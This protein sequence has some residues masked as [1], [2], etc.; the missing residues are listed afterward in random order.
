MMEN[1]LEI[2]NK[3]KELGYTLKP[4]LNEDE[5]ALYEIFRNVVDTG[6]QFPYRSNSMQEF[7][8]QFFAPESCVYVCRSLTEVVGGF[9]VK[10]NFSGRSSHIANAAYMIKETHRGQGIGTLLIKASLCIAKDLGF[11]ALQFNMVLSQNIAAI[12]LYQ[13]LGFN[14]IGAIPEAVQNPDGSYQNGYVMHRK[15]EDLKMDSLRNLL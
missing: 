1:L 3:L 10:P 13:K 8:R 4:F 6:C 5:G 7:C 12:K 9:Y 14:M 11:Q 2:H 15:L